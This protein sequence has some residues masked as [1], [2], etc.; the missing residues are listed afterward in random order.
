MSLYPS[1]ESIASEMIK[2]F[3][4]PFN[5]W[6]QKEENSPEF[7]M[8][9]IL[10]VQQKISFEY[11]QTQEYKPDD[12]AYYVA[13]SQFARLGKIPKIG[14][15]INKSESPHIGSIKRIDVDNP[16]GNIDILYKIYTG[17]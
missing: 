16:D 6:S 1:I 12:R 9:M 14:D 3:G 7:E 2:A 4:G 15:A 17:S 8:N 11:I 13:G 5:Y 10:A